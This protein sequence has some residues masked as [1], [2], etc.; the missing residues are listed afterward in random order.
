MYMY[1]YV[2]EICMYTYVS[3]CMYMYVYVSVCMCMDIAERA[4]RTRAQMSLHK[5]YGILTSHK[6]TGLIIHKGPLHT[7]IWVFS[8][9]TY[10]QFFI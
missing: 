5:V 2:D 7:Y 4:L 3:I 1:V 9:L 8:R 6:P 10:V